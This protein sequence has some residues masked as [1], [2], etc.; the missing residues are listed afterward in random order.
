M[1]LREKPVQR[2]TA[3]EGVRCLHA[4]RD[5]DERISSRGLKYCLSLLL[6]RYFGQLRHESCE[7]ERHR[8]AWILMQAAPPLR[9]PGR[10]SDGS[11]AASGSAS[12]TRSSTRISPRRRPRP[13]AGL[14]LSG[15][16]RDVQQELLRVGHLS[17]RLDG[18]H[19][20]A[21]RFGIEYREQVLD[22]GSRVDGVALLL[23]TGGREMRASGRV[24]P[25]AGN[26]PSAPAGRPIQADPAGSKQVG[27]H[28]WTPAAL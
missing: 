10:S 13:T 22:R 16:V 27:F 15:G 4:A 18:W 26:G 3:A 11:G 24:S 9:A 12:S 25:A 7:R 17:D 6:H 19:A 20:S 5:G 2:R 14:V 1:V 21:A 28:V 8:L 23:V